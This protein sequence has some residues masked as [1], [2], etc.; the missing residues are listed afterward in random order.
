MKAAQEL[1]LKNPFGTFDC[2]KPNLHDF[3]AGK[4]PLS[5]D[6]ANR[7]QARLHSAQGDAHIRTQIVKYAQWGCANESSIHYDHLRP[8]DG[9]GSPEQLPLRTDWSGFATV[10]YKW[11]GGPDPNGRNF[12]GAGW[13]GDMITTGKHVA[14]SAVKPGD[15]LVY[16]GPPE[17]Q[18]ACVVIEPGPDPKLVTHGQEKGPFEVSF[19]AETAA[20]AGQPV[21]WL[22]YLR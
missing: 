10:C 5:T 22:A 8:I 17:R 1:L 2:G 3:L 21:Y 14:Q 18:H 15:L 20:H 9:L 4:R 12:C 19:S 11:A 6:Y 16:G 13:T 7:R